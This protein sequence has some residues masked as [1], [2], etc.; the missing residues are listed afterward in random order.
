MYF[1]TDKEK[2]SKCE[3]MSENTFNLLDIVLR[4]LYDIEMDLK[5]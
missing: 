3:K 5:E 2:D 4:G 1:K